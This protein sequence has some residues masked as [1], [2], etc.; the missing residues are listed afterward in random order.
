MNPSYAITGLSVS[1][2]VLTGV[3]VAAEPWST[4]T[5]NAH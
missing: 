4:V 2:I 5:S 1:V 3:A